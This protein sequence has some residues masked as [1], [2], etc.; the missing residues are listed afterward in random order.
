MSQSVEA[1]YRAESRRV[2]A[3]LIRLLG[4]FDGAEEA[5]QEAFRAAVEQWPLEG[6]PDNPTAWLITAGRRRA[7]DRLRQQS[8]LELGDVDDRAAPPLDPMDLAERHLAAD[9]VRL[10]FACCHPALPPE[11]QVALTL[12]GVCGLTSEEIAS[13]FLVP[14]ATLYQ[15][16]VRAKAKIKGD[17]L[18]YRVPEPAELPARL[19][20][21]LRVVYL[22]FNEGYAASS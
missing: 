21:V 20:A 7:I 11:G 14:V 3:T 6:T 1:I 2:L 12:R 16:I 10:V 19:D 22:V 13:A 9:Q 5:M 17:R 8:R 18:P 15:R 4:D